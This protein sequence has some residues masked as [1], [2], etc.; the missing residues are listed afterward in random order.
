[1]NTAPTFDVDAI[2]ADFPILNRDVNGQSLAY[3]DSAATSQRPIQV[4]EAMR[5]FTQQSNANISRSVHTL[6]AE[7]T[8]AYEGARARIADFIGAPA[9]EEIVFVK[10][11]TEGI[12]LLAYA[13][14]NASAER[15]AD[16]RFQLG[17]GDEIVITEM[18]HHSNLVPWQQLAERTGATLKW[19]EITDHGRIEL[20]NLDEVIT[21][22]C[23]I[24]SFVHVSNLLGTV[25]PTEAIVKRAREV[26]ALVAMDGSQAA[27]HIPV[28]VT[29]LGVDFYIFT[30]HKMLG[31]TG[32]GAIWGK[33]ELLEAMPPFISGGS[34]VSTVTMERTTFAPPPAKFEGGTPP[35]TEAVGWHVAIDYLDKIGM[36]NVR[37]HEKELAAYMLDSLD[38]VDG[39]TVIG[40][41]VPIGRG[42]TVSFD[43]DGVHPHDVGQVLDA[44]GVAVRVG[45]HCAKPT[46][47]RFGVNA[48]TRAS[49]YI[50]TTKSEIDRLAS[51][52][53]KVRDV[54]A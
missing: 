30:G 53:D 42:A 47:I 11:S 39:L 4:T 27:P 9:A 18:E 21:D 31:P 25:N 32:I 48:T 38:Q 10:N 49:A 37:S 24:V 29:E 46:C 28:N 43:L 16:A 15:G 44:H 54:F 5:E 1:M 17:P 7:A 45:H 23:K 2:R 52:L 34:M 33:T 12:N 22:R 36:D 6:G 13:F 40:P 50:Y 51:A 26:G 19:L 3:L 41:K 35:I 14:Q 8:E 20:E